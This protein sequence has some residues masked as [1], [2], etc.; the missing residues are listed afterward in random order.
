MVH[1]EIFLFLL[2]LA[3]LWFIS[4]F[5]VEAAKRISAKLK[6]SEIFIG[7]TIA[8]IG[9]SLPEIFISVVSGWDRLHGIETSGIALGNIIGSHVAQ[10]T[11]I[12]GIVGMFTVLHFSKQELMRNGLIMLAVIPILFVLAY[13]GLQWW[14]GIIMMGLYVGYIIYISKKERVVEKVRI[15]NK[16]NSA[17]LDVLIVVVGLF[18][19]V[20][21]A[22]LLVDNGIFLG[23]VFGLSP[24]I[25]GLFVGLSTSFPELTV[26]LRAATKK[27][28]RLSLGNL[29]GSNITDPLFSLGAG[30][31]FAGFSVAKDILRFDFIYWFVVSAIAFFMLW[32]HR[33]L[34]KK[35][36]GVLI[37]LY[38]LFIYLKLFLL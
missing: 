27:A 10:I 31:V 4:T 17:I 7:L 29:I 32:N 25:I 13:N 19:I 35:E 38:V 23:E 37:A 12:L 22:K 18:L 5:V 14:E 16:T 2:G 21:S 3:G 26:S 15:N 36:S 28:G 8:S 24:Y 1:N 11:I 20:F 9:T 34:N 30:T 6:I 33:N